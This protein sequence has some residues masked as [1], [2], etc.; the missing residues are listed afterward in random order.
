EI[1]YDTIRGRI[2]SR[3]QDRGFLLLIGQMKSSTGFAAKMYTRYS[4]DPRAYAARMSIWESFGW[5]KFTDLMGNRQS[6]W[7]DCDR[8]AITTKALAGLQGFPAHVIEIPQVYYNDFAF[9]PFKAL[10]DLAGR[11]AAVASP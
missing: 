2:S 4:A 10:R 8:M 7:F 9:A 11:P 3:F 5:D 6:F 1:G